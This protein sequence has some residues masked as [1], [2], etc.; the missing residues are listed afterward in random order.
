MILSDDENYL[1]CVSLFQ[2]SVSFHRL[3]QKYAVEDRP[4]S[5]GSLYQ[6]PSVFEERFTLFWDPVVVFEVNDSYLNKT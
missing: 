3:Q 4:S 5:F 6:D 2:A 1:P